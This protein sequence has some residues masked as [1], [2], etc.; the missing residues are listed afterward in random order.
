[1]KILNNFG[2]VLTILRE[3]RNITQQE[4]ADAL[5]ISRHTYAAYEYNRVRFPIELLIP[6]SNHLDYSLDYILRYA[7]QTEQEYNENFELVKGLIE[8]GMRNPEYVPKVLYMSNEFNGDFNGCVDISYMVT[9]MDDVHRVRIGYIIMDIFKSEYSAGNIDVP[10]EEFNQLCDELD[11]I[12]KNRILK[13]AKDV[14]TKLQKGS[15]D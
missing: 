13:S 8:W 1:M 11:D 15:G 3:S 4:L 7:K 9:K 12:L 5:G 6:L 14:F 10:E 2:D